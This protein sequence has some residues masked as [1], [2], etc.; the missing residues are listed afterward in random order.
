MTGYIV[1][2]YRK[3]MK[4]VNRGECANDGE[5][6]G[7]SNRQCHECKHHFNN[8]YFCVVFHFVLL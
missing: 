5:H 7:K 2:I 8:V 1:S 3:V 6:T 4:L